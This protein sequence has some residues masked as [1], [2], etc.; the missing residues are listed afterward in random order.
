MSLLEGFSILDPS[1]IRLHLSLQ[2]NHGSKNLEVFNDHYGTQNIIDSQATKTES[3]T[4]KSVVVS[5]YELKQLTIQQLMRYIIK[6]V[7]YNVM[8]PSL[9]K[10]AAIGFLLP[11][12]RVDS[13]TC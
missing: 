7:E 2:P 5:N 13:S 3:R 4:F 9:S 10:L 11:M 6:T 12:S 1:T 8:F